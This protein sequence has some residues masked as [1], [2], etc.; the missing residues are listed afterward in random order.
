MAV[1]DKLL[2]RVVFKKLS[3][4]LT[5]GMDTAKKIIQRNLASASSS[6]F[7]K[8]FTRLSE[9]LPEATSCADRKKILIVE[10]KETVNKIKTSEI[11]CSLKKVWR[12]HSAS[13]ITVL[14]D[15]TKEREKRGKHQKISCFIKRKHSSLKLA[16]HSLSFDIRILFFIQK[17]LAII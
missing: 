4:K 7:T 2:H 14:S 3:K 8:R 10:A 15:I 12:L 1:D 5:I 9:S 13:V 16:I 11:N 6:I 17:T